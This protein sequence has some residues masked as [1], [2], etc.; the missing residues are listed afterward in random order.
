M[1]VPKPSLTNTGAPEG[2]SP[3]VLWELLTVTK[4]VGRVQWVFSH[5]ST[6]DGTKAPTIAV[7]PG[8]ACGCSLPRPL[9]Q[10]QDAAGNAIQAPAFGC[11]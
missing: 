11:H 8:W 10:A 7:L 1:M 4:P 3:R 5:L 9:P 2:P 6:G